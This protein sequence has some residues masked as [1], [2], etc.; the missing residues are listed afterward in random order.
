MMMYNEETYYGG[1]RTRTFADIFPN[2]DI[3]QEAYSKAEIPALLTNETNI[4]TIYYLLYSRYG[5][6]HISFSDE[7]QF[8]YAL[9]ATI[10]QYGPAWERRLS[11]QQELC[12]MTDEE[13]KLG[14]EATYNSA[15]NPSNAP[16]T[17]TREGVGY[18]NSQ[19]K[20][21]YTKSRL[22]GYANLLALVDTDVTEEFLRRFRPL[23][24]KVLAWDRPLLYSTDPNS[25]TG[26][27]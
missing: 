12:R 18:I 8:V 9:L 6:S 10:F 17:D 15:L 27:I 21:L 3:F 24:I 14:S 26:D 4:N 13:L 2:A 25:L 1:Y 7:N 11:V 5:N 16:G 20:T 19:N 23:F 22:E